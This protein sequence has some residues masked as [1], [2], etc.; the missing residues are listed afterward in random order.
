MK[1]VPT[2]SKYF[3]SSDIAKSPVKL[4]QAPSKTIDLSSESPVP[5]A[6][7]VEVDLTDKESQSQQQTMISESPQATADEMIGSPP[8]RKSAP[9]KLAV[10]K[11]DASTYS[12][13]ALRPVHV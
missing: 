11:R 3:A 4:Q 1:A 9:V 2:Q 10:L 5:T 7:V 13:D 12:A 8:V 6:N